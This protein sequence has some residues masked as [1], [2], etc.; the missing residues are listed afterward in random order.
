MVIDVVIDVV[1]GVFFVYD[2]SPIAVTLRETTPSLLAFFTK[3]CSII[4][5]VVA[6]AGLFD[7]II[8]HSSNKIK[9]SLGKQT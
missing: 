4:G 1:A 9:Q 3:V 8:Y 6:V 7:G 5:G 2:L